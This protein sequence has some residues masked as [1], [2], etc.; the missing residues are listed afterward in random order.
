MPIHNRKYLK[1]YRKEL[2]NNLTPQEARV[3]K[4]LK[5]QKLDGRKFRRQHSIGN[6]IAD[7][8]CPSEK[9]VVEIDGMQHYSDEGKAADARRDAYFQSMGIRVVR[10]PNEVVDNKFFV[11]AE[12]IREVFSSP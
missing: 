6:Y 3:W 9:L 4:L 11:V 7:F 1:T 10:I 8:Y 2:R 12:A 5:G